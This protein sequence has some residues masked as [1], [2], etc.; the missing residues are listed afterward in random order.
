M[1]STNMVK[2]MTAI[3]YQSIPS[4]TI[5]PPHFKSDQFNFSV[6]LTHQKRKF[7]VLS[8]K[9]YKRFHFEVHVGVEVLHRKLYWIAVKGTYVF[10]LQEMEKI[11]RILQSH[12]ML[13]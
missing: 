11:C 12:A 13:V 9:R 4:L 6:P 7:S 8:R 1:Q 10:T 3:M 2:V 5:L